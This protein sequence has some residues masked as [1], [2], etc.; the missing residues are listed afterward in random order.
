[1]DIWVC[2]NCVPAWRKLGKCP[3][4]EEEKRRAQRRIEEDAR[5]RAEEEARRLAEANAKKKHD[6]GFL[7]GLAVAWLI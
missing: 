4:C 2:T 6:D 1:M 3:K 5:R 7:A